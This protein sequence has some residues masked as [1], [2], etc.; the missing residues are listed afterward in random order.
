MYGHRGIAGTWSA[1]LV[2]VPANAF[3]DG[4]HAGTVT[5]LI[6]GLIAACGL[7]AVE[8]A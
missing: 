3:G 2:P 6:S 1:S 5:S 8:G 4:H 7:P